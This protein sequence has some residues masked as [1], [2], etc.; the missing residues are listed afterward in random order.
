[1]KNTIKNILILTVL[2]LLFIK[3]PFLINSIINGLDIFKTKIFSSIFPIM[4]ISDLLL[5]SNL[6]TI[7]SNLFGKIFTRVFKV[8]KY[9]SYVFIMSFFSGCP[10]NAKYIKDLLNNKVINEKEAIKILSM[11]MLYNPLLILNISPLNKKDTIYLLIINLLSNILIGII[12]R[13]YYIKESNYLIKSKDFNLIE[14]ISNSINTLLLILGSIITFIS[15][16]SILPIKHPLISGILEI[17]NGIYLIKTVSIYK[18]KLIFTSILLSFGGLSILYQIKS[19]FK[20]TNIDYTLYYK[21]RI[22]HLLLMLLL[23]YIKII[24]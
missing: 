12:N 16:N 9:A 17:T 19:I 18:Y 22:I 11:T 7:I 13:N 10:T 2:I 14:S 5:S 3:R 8:S 6:I 4:I 23:T 15:L 21:S 1:M 20:D 24:I